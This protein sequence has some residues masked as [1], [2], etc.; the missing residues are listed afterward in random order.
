ME[1]DADRITELAAIVSQNTEA[2][3]SHIKKHNLPPLSFA[4]SAP[5]ALPEELEGAR[6]AVVEA[7]EELKLLMQGPKEMLLSEGVRLSLCFSCLHR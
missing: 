4:A 1:R 2:I 3:S 7:T 6:T 5:M